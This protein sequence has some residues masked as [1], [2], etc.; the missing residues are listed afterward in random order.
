MATR[1]CRKKTR[2]MKRSPVSDLSDDLLV[3]IISRVPYQSTCCCKCVSRRWRDL[4]S[5]PDHRKKL[6]RSTLAGIFYQTFGGSGRLPP[7]RFCGYRSV[8][9]NFYSSMDPSLSFLP[10]RRRVQFY[11]LDCCNG[12]LLS[13]NWDQPYGVKNF[14]YV[15]CNPATEKW[16]VVPASGWSCKVRITRLGF[17]PTVSSHFHVFEFAASAIPNAYRQNDVHASKQWESTHPKLEMVHLSSRSCH[18]SVVAVGVDGTRGFIRVPT[19][20]GGNDLYLSQGQLCL[21]HKDAS[22]LS[23]WALEDYSSENWTLKYKVSHLQLLGLMCSMFLG[24]VFPKF[25]EGDY[26]GLCIPGCTQPMFLGYYRVISIHPEHSLIFFVC[27]KLHKQ[28]ERSLTKLMS[29]DMDS[30]ELH[31]ICELGRGCRTPYLSYVPLFSE[32]LADGH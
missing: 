10:K 2:G 18:N 3:E 12:L 22:E 32:S 21:A 29:Y 25:R 20:C 14:E 30:R 26:P 7:A 6:P 19:P 24:Y 28:G 23:V 27:Q 1:G 8:S 4:L 5:H 31:F 9:G 16:V 13:R 15:V 11:L 17:D